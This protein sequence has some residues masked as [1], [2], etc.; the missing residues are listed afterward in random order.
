MPTLLT[1]PR[2]A[3][4]HR[5]WSWEL[6]ARTASAGRSLSGASSIVRT[7][8][9]G[10]W[11]FSMAGVHVVNE[12]GIRLWH[13]LSALLDGGA[14]PVAMPVRQR[15][16]IS[17][18]ISLATNSDDSTLD[19]G[20]RYV[21]PGVLSVLQ[22][23]AGLRAT[24][25]SITYS[26]ASLVAGMMFSIDHPVHRH[27]LYRIAQ[28]DDGGGGVQ[29][30]TIRPPLREAATSGTLLE[31]G[32]PHCVMQLATPDGMD[33]VVKERN[34]GNPSLKWVETFPP[35]AVGA[36]TDVEI[37]VPSDAMAWDVDD[38]VIWR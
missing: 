28:V 6:T 37:P 23:N 17:P 25:L 21:T 7:D 19:D 35:F 5:T 29:T 3:L 10:A 31:F 15:F 36:V 14:R 2:A 1:F 34:Y 32:D 13:A 8:G 4:R 26:G 16:P 38:L 24:R 11:V 30:I 9:G 27:R 18:A 33:L 20:G 12:P 22:G